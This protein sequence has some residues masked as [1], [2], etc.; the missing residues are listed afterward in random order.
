MNINRPAESGLHGLALLSSFPASLTG[1]GFF[2]SWITLLTSDGV[3]TGLNGPTHDL[4]LSI[5]LVVLALFARCITPIF[6]KRWALVTCLAVA[7]CSSTLAVG[8]GV[9]G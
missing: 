5:V 1:L 9:T 3:V 8:I 6:Q 2:R 7:L 4:A